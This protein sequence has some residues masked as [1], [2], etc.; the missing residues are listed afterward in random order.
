MRFLRLFACLVEMIKWNS[1]LFLFVSAVQDPKPRASNMLGLPLKHTLYP[2][3]SS[4]HFT[5]KNLAD[6]IPPA[7]VLEPCPGSHSPHF[8]YRSP[9]FLLT[10]PRLTLWPLEFCLS[11]NPLS[12]KQVLAAS[13][14][15]PEGG[16]E[17]NLWQLF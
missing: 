3:P 17:K 11:T 15:K 5:E 9:C 4:S 6:F 16:N 12:R 14:S 7:V 10:S 13:Y 8:L 2:Q 1:K